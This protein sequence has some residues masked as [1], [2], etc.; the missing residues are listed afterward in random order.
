[1]YFQDQMA[2]FNN[3]K[4][5]LHLHQPNRWDPLTQPIDNTCSDPGHRFKVSFQLIRLNQNNKPTL[6]Q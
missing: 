6:N 2:K 3:A 1:M 5:W 4:L